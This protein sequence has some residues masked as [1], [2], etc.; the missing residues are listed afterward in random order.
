[1]NGHPRLYVLG[2][3]VAEWTARYGVEPF[4]HPCSDCGRTLTTT[5]PFMQG[6][7]RGL[8]AP[9]CVCGQDRAP[10]AL[11]RDPKYGDLFTGRE[12]TAPRRATRRAGGAS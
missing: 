2:V 3:T 11:V 10:Y 9:P 7:L 5:R 1:M 8:A 6:A 12:P 4:T